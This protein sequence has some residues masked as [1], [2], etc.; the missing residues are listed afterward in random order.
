MEEYDIGMGVF[1]GKSQRI[2]EKN[3][4]CSNREKVSKTVVR[5]SLFS[6]ILYLRSLQ[7]RRRGCIHHPGLTLEMA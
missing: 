3:K 6:P 4:P 2:E 5:V 7:Y 1:G